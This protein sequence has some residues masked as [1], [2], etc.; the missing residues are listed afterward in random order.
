MCKS[1]KAINCL[2]GNTILTGPDPKLDPGQYGIR[3]TNRAVGIYISCLLLGLYAENH[4][5]FNRSRLLPRH[6][7]SE[8]GPAVGLAYEQVE[9][10]LQVF[11]FCF[12]CF[13]ILFW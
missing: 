10:A 4:R 13:T 7:H 1:R 8:S 2:Y 12:T 9:S 3:I 5:C 6:R 11:L